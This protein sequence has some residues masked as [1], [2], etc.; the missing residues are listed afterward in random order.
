MRSLYFAGWF[1][2]LLMAC[3]PSGHG[4]TSTS[5]PPP[6]EAPEEAPAEAPVVQTSQAEPPTPPT[7]VP[8]SRRCLPLVSGCGC[9]HRCADGFQQADLSWGVPRPMGDSALDPVDLQQWVFD[10]AGS[11]HMRVGEERD[12]E[13]IE[14]FYDRTPCGGE[15]IPSRTFLS[16]G[17]IDGSCSPAP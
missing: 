13:V 10:A 14:V 6:D 8:Q 5:E 17:L 11:G 7:G 16:C 1:G 2:C 9:A 15:C 12:G 4:A 3:G